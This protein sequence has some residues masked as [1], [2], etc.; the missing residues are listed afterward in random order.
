MIANISILLISTLCIVYAGGIVY[1]YTFSD[2]LIFPRFAPSYEDTEEILKL[3]SDDGE[4]ISALYLAANDAKHLLLYSH[5]NGE[6]LGEIR[7]LLEDFR[8]R[9]IAVFAYDYPGYGTSTGTAS[10]VGV[11]A[12]TEAAYRYV[13]QTLGYAPK[14]ITLYGRSLGS[15]PSCYLAEHYPVGGLILDGAFSS[16]FRVMTRVKILPWD[17]FDN[18]ARLPSIQ[19]PTLLLHGTEDSTVPFAHALQNS[20]AIRGIK[21]TVWVEGAGHNDLIE[22]SGAAYWDTVLPFIQQEL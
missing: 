3:Q 13:T 5:G 7:P 11:Y 20:A 14:A 22:Q 1:A 2:K 15:G 12:A 6:D 16:T 10:E 8:S 18:V 19:C 21:H 4:S 17:K 9:G